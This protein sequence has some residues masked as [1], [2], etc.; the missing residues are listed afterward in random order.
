MS[1]EHAQGDS[2]KVSFHH[3][4]TTM[5][6]RQLSQLELLALL[7]CDVI[8]IDQRNWLLSKKTWQ[9]NGHEVTLQ[10]HLK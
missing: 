5:K 6:E 7:N 10:I 8:H 9:D 2:I 3:N 4:E 1:M